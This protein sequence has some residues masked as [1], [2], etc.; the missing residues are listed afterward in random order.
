MT[1]VLWT[2]TVVSHESG[3]YHEILSSPW[4]G[5]FASETIW[6]TFSIPQFSVSVEPQF[7]VLIRVYLIKSNSCIWD[8]CPALGVGDNYIWCLLSSNLPLSWEDRHGKQIIKIQDVKPRDE[9][10]AVR[11]KSRGNQVCLGE[12]L[13]TQGH[14]EFVKWRG[15]VG[16]PWEL[17]GDKM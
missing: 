17:D 15:V 10:N 14:Q 16:Y 9:K 5:I 8:R 7:V 4:L 1:W 12:R 2:F 13:H 3:M 6:V 11:V